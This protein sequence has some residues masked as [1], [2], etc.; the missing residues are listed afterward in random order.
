MQTSRSRA[1][2]QSLGGYPEDIHRKDSKLKIE[3]KPKIAANI[4]ETSLH[5]AVKNDQY[6]TV[7]LLLKHNWNPI[8]SKKMEKI[9][10]IYH[11]SKEIYK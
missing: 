5:Q 6:E 7:E 1:L 10:C 9:D 8:Y 4:G 3:A 2:K 11:V